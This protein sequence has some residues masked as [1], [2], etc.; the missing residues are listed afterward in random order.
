MTDHTT[1]HDDCG[2][3]SARLEAEIERL[4]QECDNGTCPSAMHERM[5]AAQAVP[6]HE[7]KALRARAE[8]AERDV[9]LLREALEDVWAA[10]GDALCSGSGIDK[11][12]ATSV[13]E[14]VNAALRS[15]AK[16][17]NVEDK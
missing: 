3:L 15:V 14:K 9:A 1:H 6:L 8:K 7:M 17:L 5:A 10:I 12:Y 13:Q 11:P 4:K 16:A 2:C